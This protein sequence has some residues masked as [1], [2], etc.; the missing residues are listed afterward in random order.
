[1]TMKKAVNRSI[2]VIVAEYWKR[3]IEVD[4]FNHPDLRKTRKE[5]DAYWDKKLNK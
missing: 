2:G 1:M 5:I 3:F 4:D